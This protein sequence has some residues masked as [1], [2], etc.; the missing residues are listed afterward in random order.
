MKY[1]EISKFSKNHQTYSACQSA[2]EIIP[3][4]KSVGTQILEDI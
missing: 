2:Q 4:N 1:Y 3:Y